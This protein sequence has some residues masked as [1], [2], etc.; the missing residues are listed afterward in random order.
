LEDVP[1]CLAGV[2][3]YQVLYQLEEFAFADHVGLLQRGVVYYEI[4]FLKNVKEVAFEF[5]SRVGPICGAR[6]REAHYVLFAF[7]LAVGVKP[8]FCLH[9]LID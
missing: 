2:K 4:E 6:A 5:K 3:L 8:V 9:I 1:S 7:E